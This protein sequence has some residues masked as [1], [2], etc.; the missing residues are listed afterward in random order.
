MLDIN[1]HEELAD[2]TASI[3]KDESLLPQLISE[4][5]N[6]EPREAELISIALSCEPDT[7]EHL[8]AATRISVLVA[9]GA[10]SSELASVAVPNPNKKKV[11]WT[12]TSYELSRDAFLDVLSDQQFSED[13]LTNPYD[14]DGKLTRMVF[15]GDSKQQIKDYLEGNSY[16]Q[17]QRDFTTIAPEDLDLQ[18]QVAL[19]KYLEFTDALENMVDPEEAPDFAAIAKE[20]VKP[21]DSNSKISEM[22]DSGA[23][24]VEIFEALSEDPKWI[25]DSYDYTTSLDVD[26]PSQEQK[27]T[28]NAFASI[29]YAIKD[30]DDR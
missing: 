23:S 13:I 16:F 29:V 27:D 4:F 25:E 10:V 21:Y 5:D 28:W 2:R 22:I 7:I 17:G 11:P 15:R 9:S 30:L 6:L 1:P 20:M 12:R 18:E 19:M 3:L 24:S 8:H 26:N 14:A